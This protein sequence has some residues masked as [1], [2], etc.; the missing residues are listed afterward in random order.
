MLH[1]SFLYIS[2]AILGMSQSLYIPPAAAQSQ[3]YDVRPQAN[4]VIGAELLRSF[5]GVTHDGA[6]NFDQAGRPGFRYTERHHKDGRVTY[7]EQGETITGR[8]S[9]T[10][11]DLICYF[12]DTILIGGGCFR[13]YKLGSCFYF[14]SSS[15][16]EKDDESEREYWTARSVKHGQK[17]SCEGMIA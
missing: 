8:W 9:V 7:K 15:A 3:T 11:T 2:L 4:R 16:V 12:Y 13:L 1:R 6:Y 14:Y 10:G 17:A 5:E